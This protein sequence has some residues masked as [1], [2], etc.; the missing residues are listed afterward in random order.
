MLE[1]HRYRE[2]QRHRHLDVPR[3]RR[4]CPTDIVEQEDPD[5]HTE[6]ICKRYE[7]A[8]PADMSGGRRVSIRINAGWEA[9][10]ATIQIGGATFESDRAP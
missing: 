6:A 7:F 3:G 4:R 8:P 1:R 5:D 2:D 9:V 10:G